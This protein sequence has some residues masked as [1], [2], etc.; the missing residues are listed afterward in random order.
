MHHSFAWQGQPVSNHGVRIKQCASNF[1]W[2]THI[3]IFALCSKQSCTFTS[4]KLPLSFLD[5]FIQR[6]SAKLSLCCLHALGEV[7]Y[8]P[9]DHKNIREVSENEKYG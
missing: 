5:Q 9:C 7:L 8:R 4:I 2:R 3:G 6:V 1:V